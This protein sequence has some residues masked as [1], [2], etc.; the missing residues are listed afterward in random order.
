MTCQDCGLWRSPDGFMRVEPSDA[1][2]VGGHYTTQYSNQGRFLWTDVPW[3]LHPSRADL[4]EG[5]MASAQD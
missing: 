2:H 1:H 5:E 4:T 3:Q